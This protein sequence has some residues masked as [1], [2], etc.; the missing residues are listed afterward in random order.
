MLLR[1]S[2]ASKAKETVNE[3]VTERTDDLMAA[4]EAAKE[5]LARATTA[6]GRKGAELGAELGKEASKAADKLLPERAKQRRRES[7]RR[8]RRRLMAG[9]AGLIGA[10]LVASRLAGSKGEELRQ[11]LKRQGDKAGGGWDR[12]DEP[13]HDADAASTAEVTQLHQ[14]NGATT[15]PARTPP[16]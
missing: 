7:A 8:R 11:G 14:G 12:V 10:G 1:K 9:A 13:G 15:N 2:K 4:L 16:S 3:Q 5:A 6:A